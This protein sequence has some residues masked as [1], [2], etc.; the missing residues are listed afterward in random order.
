MPVKIDI[1]QVPDDRKNDPRFKHEHA[2]LVTIYSDPDKINNIAVHEAAHAIYLERAGTV[3]IKFHGPRI[4]YNV[5]GDIFDSCSA[6][7][8]G[9]GY[10][11]NHQ[12]NEEWVLAIAKA[13]AAGGVA[14]LKLTSVG[15]SGDT[16]DRDLFEN[17]CDKLCSTGSITITD[18]DALWTLA[19]NEVENELLDPSLQHEIWMKVIE[20][21]SL[22][23]IE[24]AIDPLSKPL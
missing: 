8:Q 23:C 2:K 4:E 9:G 5:I 21:I 3:N 20:I 19:Q 10:D 7:V 11:G 24:E 6:Y 18:R 13:H 17:A 12:L 1:T 14:A 22:I 16:G 15:V